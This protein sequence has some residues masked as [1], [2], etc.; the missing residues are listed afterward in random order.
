MT[1]VLWDS[2]GA[3]LGYLLI[4]WMRRLHNRRSVN[5]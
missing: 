5:Q 1:D 3:L 2:L 4:L